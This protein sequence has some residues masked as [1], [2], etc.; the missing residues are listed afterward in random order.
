M[1]PPVLGCSPPGWRAATSS[2]LQRRVAP[3]LPAASQPVCSCVLALLM[4]SCGLL[5]GGEALLV[6]H[7]VDMP[8]LFKVHWAL[9]R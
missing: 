2:R 9:G 1:S 7:V 3:C 6:V 5:V 4:A 8:R